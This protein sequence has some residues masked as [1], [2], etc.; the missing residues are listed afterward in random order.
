MQFP[1]SFIFNRLVRS[2]MA[3]HLTCRNVGNAKSCRELDWLC[4]AGTPELIRGSLVTVSLFSLFLVIAQ[5]H[6]YTVLSTTHYIKYTIA[7]HIA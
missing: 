3:L 6:K 2:K 5:Q 7:I 1:V 4:S